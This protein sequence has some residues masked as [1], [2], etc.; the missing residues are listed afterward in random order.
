MSS[1]NLSGRQKMINMMYLVL[2]AMLAL[3]VS[4]EILK[5]F[6]II[7]NGMIHTGKTIDDRNAFIIKKFDQ[8]MKNDPIK[9]KPQYEKALAVKKITDDAV[10]AIEKLKQELIDANDGREKEGEFKGQLKGRDNMEKHAYIL[11]SEQ[12][13]KKGKQLKQLINETKANILK[14]LPENERALIVSAQDL[15]AQDNPEK[16]PMTWEEEMFEHT[17]L[18]AVVTILQKMENDVKMSGSEVM[19]HFSNKIYVDDI[20]VDKMEAVVSNKTGGVVAVGEPFEAEIFVAASS[21]SLTPTVT[22]NGQ[23]LPVVNGKAIYKQTASNGLHNFNG[24][25]DVKKPNG[26]TEHLKFNSSYMGF[27][28]TATIAADAMNVIYIG[29][30]NPISVSVPGFPMENVIVNSSNANLTRTGNNGKYIVKANEADIKNGITI[31]AS[32]KTSDGRIRPMGNMKFRVMRP[33][34]PELKLGT[35]TGGNI[36]K[37]EL[38]GVKSLTLSPQETF[39]FQ[40]VPYKL[41]K[42]TLGIITKKTG[43]FVPY[44]INNEVLSNEVVT[45]LRQCKKGD[46]ITIYG[47]TSD[48]KGV[49]Q[50]LK[51]GMLLNVEN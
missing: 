22:L 41:V 18:A 10:Q 25:I 47:I 24:S 1:T 15:N 38:L 3:N 8:G 28:G 42:A 48:F 32:V 46:I 17:P 20:P 49:R 40:N 2:T 11:V 13:P 23:T 33:A 26:Q 19:E 29:P 50:N 5:A 21:S 14:L 34:K 37:E 9:T 36:R 39:V 27:S 51:N 7:E 31:S 43:A 30:E 6:H 16:K 12:G 45:A 44:D 4:S 35:L